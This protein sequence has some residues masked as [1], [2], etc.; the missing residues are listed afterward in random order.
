MYK[1]SVCKKLYHLKK[2]KSGLFIISKKNNIY[3]VLLMF[4]VLLE[5]FYV[6]DY[7]IFY[8]KKFKFKK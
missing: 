1:D 4:Q 7:A 5:T 8:Y 3:W 2:E 6:K